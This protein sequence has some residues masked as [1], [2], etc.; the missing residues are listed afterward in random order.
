MSQDAAV[1]PA[2]G[3][4]RVVLIIGG[5][6]RGGAERVISD[7]ANYWCQKGWQITLA[8]WSGPQVEDFYALD[9]RVERLWLETSAPDSTINRLASFWRGVR[10]CRQILRRHRPTAV[11]SFIDISNILTLIASWRL[12]HRVIV[13]VRTNPLRTSTV[14][15]PWRV[16]R[17]LTYPRADDIV[18][19]TAGVAEWMAQEWR[20]DSTVVPN[21]VRDLPQLTSVREDLVVAI[22]RLAPVKGFDLL[23]RAFAR[24][25]DEHDKWRLVI[26]GAGPEF[27]RLT[28]LRDSLDVAERVAIL[29]PVDDVESWLAR[30]GLVVQ[31][32]RYEGFPNVVLEAMGMG[33]AVV[34]AD[35]AWG[36]GDMIEDGVNG[37]LVPVDNVNALASVMQELIKHPEVRVS[38]GAEAEKVRQKF[39][40]S[41]VMAQWE[42]LLC[43]HVN[44]QHGTA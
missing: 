35:C 33:A 39:A 22:G 36:P 31:P 9:S 29:E 23:L 3:V 30:A 5:L 25:A 20:V 8:T 44:E 28:E 41:V 18:A 38:L 40:Q 1:P 43:S 34:A 10:R 24:I 7:M 12:P 2:P 6:Q 17:R 13:S 19:Q 15:L 26:I 11:V 27:E 42:R 21:A 16:L 4:P 32:S 37:R 14:S